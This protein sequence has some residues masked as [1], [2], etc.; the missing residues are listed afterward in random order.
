[1]YPLY[2]YGYGLVAGITDYGTHMDFQI[3]LIPLLSLVGGAAGAAVINGWFGL[4][5]LKADKD[6]EHATWRRNEKRSAYVDFLVECEAVASQYRILT[7]NHDEV[8]DETDLDAVSSHYWRI[9]IMAPGKIAAEA[10]NMMLALT[11]ARDCVAMRSH[12]YDEEYMQRMGTYD[13][14][15]LEFCSLVSTDLGLG[16]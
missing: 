9:Q 8:M 6:T 5:K 12:D 7:L 11:L 3:W 14:A 4:H 13:Q 16:R 15:R 10:D 2:I 1:M